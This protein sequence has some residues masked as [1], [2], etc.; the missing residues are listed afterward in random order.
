MSTGQS[1]RLQTVYGQ[2]VHGCSQVTGWLLL[3]CKVPSVTACCLLL[4]TKML[5]AQLGYA[6]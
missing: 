6:S 5:E 3:N 1:S 2:N 4:G